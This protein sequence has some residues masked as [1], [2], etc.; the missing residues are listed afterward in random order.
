MWHDSSIREMTHCRPV[1]A[2]FQAEL[3]VYSLIRAITHSF[4]TRL[5]RICGWV[6]LHMWHD[7]LQTHWSTFSRATRLI[8]MWN[9]SFI[10]E[11]WL[12][13]NPLEHIFTC[14]ILIFKL[15]NSSII[16]MTHSYVTWLNHVCDVTHCRPIGAHFHVPHGL[17]NAMLLPSI[18]AFSLPGAPQR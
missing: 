18:T 9:D 11:A 5:I 2:C 14:H 16:D 8:H 1:G 3:C 7:S 13:A 17:S 12:I 15:Q 10:Y 4:A 6:M